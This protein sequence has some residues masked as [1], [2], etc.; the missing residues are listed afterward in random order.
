[1][2]SLSC[3]E[4]NLVLRLDDSHKNFLISSFLNNRIGFKE[5]NGILVYPKIDVKIILRVRN[6]F[7][8]LAGDLILD[9]CCKKEIRDYEESQVNLKNL[10]EKAL[11]IKDTPDKD[12]TNLQIP[13]FRTDKPTSLLPY[14]IKPVKHALTIIN[15]AN[16]AVPGGGKTWMAYSTFFYARAEASLPVVDRLLI[17][18]PQ[19]AFQVWEEEYELITGQ[20]STKKIRRISLKDLERGLLPSFASQYEILLINYEK[21][22]NLRILEALKRLLTNTNFFVILDESHK[23]KGYDTKSG[24]G[25]RKLAPLAKRRMILTGTPMPNFHLGLWNQFNFLFPDSN[26]LG[27]Y[28][29]YSHQIE[30]KPFQQ[31]VIEKL[32]PAYTRVTEKQLDL[33]EPLPPVYIPCTMTEFQTKIYETIA[34]DVVTG[35]KNKDWFQALEDYERKM[36]YLIEAST[37]P[38]LLKKDNQ[39]SDVLID[40]KDVDIHELLDEYGSGELSGKMLVLQEL[41]KPLIAKK[42][43]VVIW[44]N[45][46]ATIEKVEKMLAHVETRK[47]YGEIDKTDEDNAEENR[48]KSLR[49]FKKDPNCNILIANPASLSE[50]VSL[51]KTCHHAI[52]VDRTYN[53]AHWIQ[54]KKRIH[55]IGI[56]PDVKTKYTILMSKYENRN[57]RTID[58]HIN[59]NLNEKEEKMAEFLADPRLN[60]VSLN[61]DYKKITDPESVEDDYKELVKFLKKKFND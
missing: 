28:T 33:P 15:S 17:I 8:P 53:A 52:Y 22:R 54:S 43:K 10:F 13:E 1:M 50:S 38:A 42:E 30:S 31:A 35:D 49:E 58:D 41:M 9:E 39:F 14:Q 45:F 20:D 5:K 34:W 12:F 4:N 3:N 29:S 57:L 23:V 46:V 26:I 61:L 25:V 6:Y 7:V 27:S 56:A 19:S 59:E 48:E 21:L 60:P 36:M 18:C 44:C 32:Y 2:S 37:D 47:I 16:F 24:E 40:L 11:E 51:H 55:R